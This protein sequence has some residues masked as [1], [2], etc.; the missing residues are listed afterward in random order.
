MIKT[1]F[2]FLENKKE[3]NFHGKKVYKHYRI[4]LFTKN[5]II[6]TNNNNLGIWYFRGFNSKYLYK[7]KY[8]KNF[9]ILYSYKIG[10]YTKASD[11]SV[12]DQLTKNFVQVRENYKNK[13]MDVKDAI[14]YLSLMRQ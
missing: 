2:S 13:E 10:H 6:I 7:S 14:V 3:F 1:I 8:I 4:K 11:I 9:K 12:E 5:C